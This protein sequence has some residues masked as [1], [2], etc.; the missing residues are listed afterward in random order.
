MAR[1]QR[2]ERLFKEFMQYHN[3]GY[4]IKDIA[5]VFEVD[6]STVYNNLQEIADANG[7]T[8]E[9]LLERG[10]S[11]HEKPHQFFSKEKVDVSNLQK[12]FKK[13]EE[14]LETLISSIDKI[15]EKELITWQI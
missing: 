11:S 1:T 5:K 8:R 4:S 6:F 15:L 12:E 9:S 3:A 7:V 14:D 10:S 2:V 13:A